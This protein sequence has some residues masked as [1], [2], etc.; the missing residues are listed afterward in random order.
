MRFIDLFWFFLDGDKSSEQIIEAKNTT[1]AAAP[2]PAQQ[3]EE[4]IEPTAPTEPVISEAAD[5]EYCFADDF[6]F[7]EGDEF[8]E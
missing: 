3:H 8:F 4:S 6:D 7:C 1:K 5:A 2:A